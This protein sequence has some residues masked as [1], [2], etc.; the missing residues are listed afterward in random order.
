[1]APAEGVQAM[2]PQEGLAV[3]VRAEPERAEVAK[4]AVAPELEWKW[5]G[6][7]MPRLSVERVCCWH[8]AE[9]EAR[10]LLEAWVLATLQGRV[11]QVPIG[12][13]ER[14]E[15]VPLMHQ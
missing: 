1:M 8:L 14:V 12:V 9:A 11:P 2:V 5:V 7:L 15:P 13:R 10:E 3:V 6:R 4:V